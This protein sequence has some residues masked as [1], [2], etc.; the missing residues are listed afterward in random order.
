MKRGHC[1][2]K[3]FADTTENHTANLCDPEDSLGKNLLSM[4]Q[5][6]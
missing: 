4:S 1:P 3:Y 6:Q 5:T 2:T